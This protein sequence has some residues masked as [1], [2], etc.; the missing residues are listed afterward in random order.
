[1]KKLFSTV[2][3]LLFG[4][5][6][7]TADDAADVKQVFVRHAQYQKSANFDAMASLYSKDYIGTNDNGDVMTYS[8]IKAVVQMLK[9]RDARTFFTIFMMATENR[10]PTADE[11]QRA[12]AVFPPAQL[13]Q[14][15]QLMM[16][17]ARKEGDLFMKTANFIDIKVFEGKTARVVL[18]YTK[19]DPEDD[20][21]QK[22]KQVKE[23]A[24]LRKE[25]GTWKIL[26][27]AEF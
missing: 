6:C 1:M 9:A 21:L 18:E 12:E 14:F 24:T 19:L 22:T 7:A 20:T 26:A 4:A 27:D 17:A 10:K 13:A 3:V 8:K 16:N 15:K 11:L 23:I 5:F 25:N 2:A